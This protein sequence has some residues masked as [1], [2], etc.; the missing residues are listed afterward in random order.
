MHKHNRSKGIECYNCML[1]DSFEKC[2]G[3][4]PIGVSEVSRKLIAKA[5]MCIVKEDFTWAAGSLQVCAGQ[6]S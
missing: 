2:L 3:I 6:E 5:I 4:W 1:F